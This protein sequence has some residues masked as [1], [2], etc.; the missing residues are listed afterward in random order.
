MKKTFLLSALAGLFLFAGCDSLVDSIDG[1]SGDQLVDG[2][3]VSDPNIKVFATFSYSL[4][5]GSVADYDGPGITEDGKE[6][7][8]CEKGGRW[9]NPQNKRTGPMV[10]PHCV[11]GAGTS[12]GGLVV[13]EEI[14]AFL[15]EAN[16]NVDWIYFEE[17][18][19]RDTPEGLFVEWQ[20]SSKKN[21]GFGTMV[22]YGTVG[23]VQTGKFAIDLSTLSYENTSGPS[24]TDYNMLNGSC[25]IGEMGQEDDED[26]YRSCL[27]LQDASG[28][29]ILDGDGYPYGRITAKYF[30]DLNADIE[31]DTPTA[32]VYGY[33]YW[34]APAQD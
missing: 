12:P 14:D 21:A 4:Q 33:L 3:R 17:D 19:D 26:L 30:S 13:L 22:A 34:E 16:R 15:G 25:F 29:D 9:L 1:P 24:G 27:R 10:H 5:G 6:L 11:R 31:T 18:S 8:Q 2:T 20:S 23:N 7:G 28:D 32:T